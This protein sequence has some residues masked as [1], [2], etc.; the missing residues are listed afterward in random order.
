M[1]IHFT[2]NH[3]DVV[4]SDDMSYEQILR[5]DPERFPQNALAVRLGGRTVSLTEKPTPGC[6][7]YLIDYHDQE[8]RRVYERSLRFLMLLALRKTYPGARVR[9]ENSIGQG[10]YLSVETPE[11]LTAHA[12]HQVET[13]MHALADQDLPYTARRVSR[14]Q[15]IEYFRADH[16]MDKV[17]LLSYRPYEYFQMYSCE[18]MQEYFYGV[19]TP[20]T[21]YVKVFSLQFYMPGMVLML[22]DSKQ[23]D[24][25][26]RFYDQPKLM[27]CFAESARWSEILGCSNAADLNEMV[28]TKNLRPFIRVNEALQEKSISGIAEQF[29]KSGA[30][31]ILIAGPS[32]S[33]KTT[34]AHRLNIALRVLGLRPVSISLDDYYIDRDKIPLEADGQPDLE[35]LSTLDVELFNDHLVR[36]LQ[37]EEVLMPRFDFETQKRA[38]TGHAFRLEEGQPVIIEGI[39]GLNDELTIDVPRD[40]KFKIYVSA[41]T[42]LNLDDHNRIRTTDARL[43]RRIVRDV[44][45]RGTDIERTMSMWPSVR[46]GEQNYIFPYQ[47]N[48]DA[49]FNSS[50]VYELAILKRYVYPLLIQVPDSSPNYTLSRRLVKFLNYF[51]SADVEDEI[52]PNSILREFIGGCCFYRND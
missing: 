39:H 40:M 2:L 6:E 23:P 41:L 32:S 12:V 9:I 31:L 21:G 49:V 22:P 8:G 3:Q 5:A 15:A 35:K 29:Q 17:R 38:P 28:A 36:L 27:H 14:Q 10:I 42:T 43:L 24:R 11:A 33:G 4:A 52:P 37:G 44:R 1:Q 7:A 18:D 20:S 13:L 51:Q 16:Q 26:A 46:R 50:L 30:R 45:F 25:P 34:F 19:M 48:A 47:E